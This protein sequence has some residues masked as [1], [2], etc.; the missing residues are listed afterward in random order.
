MYAKFLSSTSLFVTYVWFPLRSLTAMVEYMGDDEMVRI[1]AY[2]RLWC[3]RAH[4]AL[5]LFVQPLFQPMIPKIMAV[6]RAFIAQD[7]VNRTPKYSI[8]SPSVAVVI[9]PYTALLMQINAFVLVC[10]F[11]MCKVPLCRP[12][13]SLIPKQIFSRNET[14]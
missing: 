9:Y 6:V 12:Y 5:S 3:R 7:E 13:H 11:W 1:L 2:T 14:I 4:T 8:H 10:Q